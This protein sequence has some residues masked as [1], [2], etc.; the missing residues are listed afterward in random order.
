MTEQR[1]AKERNRQQSNENKNGKRKKYRAQKCQRGRK[2]KYIADRKRQLEWCKFE[3][4]EV[5]SKLYL[6]GSL[7]DMHTH[8]TI[9]EKQF[10]C[11]KITF[12]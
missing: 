3:K 6:W 12:G 4:K 9:V 8:K 7:I 5:H 10:K 1:Y 2:T 11:D